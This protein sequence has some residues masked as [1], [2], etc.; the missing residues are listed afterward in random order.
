MVHLKACVYL[1]LISV[2]GGPEDRL[3]KAMS[4]C[5]LT[6]LKKNQANLYFIGIIIWRGSCMDYLQTLWWVASFAFFTLANQKGHH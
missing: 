3:N 1:R 2:E 6:L 4:Y 5:S